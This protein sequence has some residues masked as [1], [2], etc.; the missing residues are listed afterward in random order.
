MISH[1]VLFKPR[2][3]LSAA[4]RRRL[5]AAFGRAIREI[6]GVRAARIG[7][8]VSTGAGYE[9]AMPDTADYLVA[10]DFDDVEGVRRYLAH[11]A[12]A[13]LGR[14]FGESTSARLVFDFEWMALDGLGDQ[15][16]CAAAEGRAAL[17]SRRARRRRARGRRRSGR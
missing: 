15:T 6:P 4:A 14:R 1:V 8:R 9:A 11:P 3:D 13:D 16:E 7:R 12:H 2:A 5:V 10:L 17:R